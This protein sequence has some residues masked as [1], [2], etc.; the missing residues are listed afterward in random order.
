MTN[1]NAGED[2]L[3]ALS[4]AWAVVDRKVSNALSGHR[5]VSFS[6]YRMLR[7]LSLAPGMRASRVDLARA[8]GL[9]PSAVTRALGPLERIGLVTTER[10]ERDARLALAVL[11]PAG[12]ELVADGTAVVRDV[13]TH[14]LDQ[15]PAADAVTLSE[16][17]LQLSRV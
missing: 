14:V 13:M 4:A 7:T 15:A 16:A 17:L 10:N 8:V 3:H 6:E 1:K 11:T 9:T 2:L 5:G 12:Q